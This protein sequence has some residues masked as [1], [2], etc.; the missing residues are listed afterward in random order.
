M[1]I[2]RVIS[3]STAAGVEPVVVQQ[4]DRES[5]TVR[6]F[7]YESSGVPLDVQGKTARIFF[8]KNGATSKAYEAAV[9]ADGW[10]SLTVP[11]E[12]TVYPGNGEMQLAIVWGSHILHSFTVPFAVRGSLSFVGETET[13]EDDPMRIAW[14]TLPG[15]P[16]TFPPS[17][18]THTPAQAGALPANGTAA[19]ASKLGGKLPK[20]YDRP[21]NLLDNSDFRNPVNQRGATTTTAWKYCIDRWLAMTTGVGLSFGASGMTV[22]GVREGS[23]SIYQ[24][25]ANHESILGK[26][27]TLAVK[28]TGADKPITLNC[29]LPSAFASTAWTTYA[30]KT[31]GNVMIDIFSSNG[32]LAATLS[33]K[34]QSSVTFEWA[35]LYVGTYTEDNLPTYVPKGY[36]AELL[37]CQR[38][39]HL[40]A[41]QAARPTH[42]LDCAPHMRLSN[43]TQ[44]TI[45]IDGATYYYNA[46]DL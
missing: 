7:V 3:L 39:Y 42:G 22:T 33:V 4:N 31:V 27:V 37:E 21:R 17:A 24:K 13:P 34:N 43:P 19:D 16:D 41:T 30:T 26:A 15:K 1:L 14:D 29:T 9:A 32:A 10:I 5:R 35:A 46:A 44:G 2:D 12:V 25:I 18:H 38:Y 28:H 36:A 6:F 45:V 11:E 20:Y 40:Y 23:N 8:R